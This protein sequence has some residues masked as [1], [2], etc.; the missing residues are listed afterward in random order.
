MGGYNEERML[1]FVALT[2]MCMLAYEQYDGIT[3]T[4]VSWAKNLFKP[5]QVRVV[6]LM[7]TSNH[8]RIR[9]RVLTRELE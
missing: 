7:H 5:Y 4:P 3:N 8:T 1:Q 2:R 9:I 6:V